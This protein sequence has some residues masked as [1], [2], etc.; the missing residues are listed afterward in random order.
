MTRMLKRHCVVC[1]FSLPHFFYFHITN[2]FFRYNALSYRQPPP[3]FMTMATVGSRHVCVSN[4]RSVFFVSLSTFCST[5]YYLQIST[6]TPYHDNDDK[7]PPWHLDTSKLAIKTRK[8]RTATSP[9]YVF[10]FFSI[11]TNYLQ[12][13]YTNTGTTNAHHHTLMDDTPNDRWPA[14]SN[15]EGCNN[16]NERGDKQ[17][18]W[19]GARDTTRL[20][21]QVCFFYFF[22]FIFLTTTYSTTRT[23]TTKPA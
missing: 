14:Q 6:T 2:F 19:G 18:Q 16:I 10:V 13:V 12:V 9:W 23:T 3:I 5:N 20:E 17:W 4:F 21:A 22:F 7:W 1:F 15:N 11:F 8:A